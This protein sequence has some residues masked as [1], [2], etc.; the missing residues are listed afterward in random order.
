M[1]A[2]LGSASFRFL[3][4]LNS[5]NLGFRLTGKRQR[6]CG[7]SHRAESHNGDEIALLEVPIVD[8]PIV[9]A[10]VPRVGGIVL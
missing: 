10:H 5:G 9:E 7:N 2:F 8:A 3:F 4:Q 1:F 6:G